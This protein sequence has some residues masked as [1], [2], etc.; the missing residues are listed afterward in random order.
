MSV[1][2]SPKFDNV[3]EPTQ[4]TLKQLV[5][6]NLE[7]KMSSYFQKVLAHKPDAE[8]YLDYHIIK[9]TISNTY[10]GKFRLHMDGNDYP[11]HR[12]AFQNPEDLVNH[13]FDRFKETLSKK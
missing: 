5:D 12:E 8:I 9:K 11:Y 3:S 10:D 7:G 2:I 13:A 6:K 1:K 4:E